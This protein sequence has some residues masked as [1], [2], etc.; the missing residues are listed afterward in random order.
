[1]AGARRGTASA[2]AVI[3]CVTA[4]CGPAEVAAPPSTLDVPATAAMGALPGP[5]SDRPTVP[6]PPTTSGMSPASAPAATA[7]PPEPIVGPI[8]DVVDGDRLL[9]IGDEVMAS[10]APR[11]GGIACDVIPGFGWT[12]EIAAEPGRFVGFADE[13]LDA[14]L[15]PGTDWDVIAVML[16]NQF[17]GSVFTYGQRLTAVV[18]RVAPRPVLVY[19][20]SE[21]GPERSDLN[22][23]IR[24]L[25]EFHPNVVVVDWAEITAAE[26]ERLL[27]DGGPE[28]TEEGSGRLVLFTAAALG[29]APGGAT[30]ECL[31]P[32][33]TDDSTIVI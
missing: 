8:G 2:L 10:I 18:E 23:L 14:R 3:A 30:G 7:T 6:P 12:V 29:E 28:L 25:P 15:R 16:G 11:F 9:V 19:T 32:I 20:V 13:V 21:I 33:F 4:A 31:P 24:G 5:P 22:Q 1:M 26:P 27:A 17:E